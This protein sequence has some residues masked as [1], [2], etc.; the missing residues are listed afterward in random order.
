MVISYHT[1]C[2]RDFQHRF[3]EAIEM[4]VIVVADAAA[5]KVWSAMGQMRNADQELSP[6]IAVDLKLP[7]HR[8]V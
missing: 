6:L 7:S 1:A 4:L 2:G 3:R 5:L 8:E